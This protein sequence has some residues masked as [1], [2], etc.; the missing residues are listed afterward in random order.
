MELVSYKLFAFLR[1]GSVVMLIKELSFQIRT[2]CG[3]G[4]YL[5]EVKFSN[6]VQI[7]PR[8]IMIN[9]CCHRFVLVMPVLKARTAEN[10]FP[11]CC[12]LPVSFRGLV[13]LYGSF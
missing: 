13:D 2:L 1:P 6:S 5:V 7:G 8:N 12:H 11:S 3:V 10:H 9:C 4:S